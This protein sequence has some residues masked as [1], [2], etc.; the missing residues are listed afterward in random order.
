MV[1]FGVDGE[2]VYPPTASGRE[3]QRFEQSV[4]FILPAM[5]RASEMLDDPESMVTG[6]DE[7]RSEVTLSYDDWF[8][9]R[10]LLL[11]AR[12]G[13]CTERW[14]PWFNRVAKRHWLA[15]KSQGKLS[16]AE[17]RRRF[18]AKVSEMP[19]AADILRRGGS[20]DACWTLICPVPG[21]THLPCSGFS[22]AGLVA[23]RFV[24]PTRTP[25][26]E[27]AEA[28]RRKKLMTTPLSGH[29]K[30][31]TLEGFAGQ[32]RHV[33]TVNMEEYLQAF[34]VGIF[35]RKA[36]VAFTPE[37]YY[38]VVRNDRLCITM[39][40]PLGSRVEWL[41]PDGPP[42]RDRDPAGNN[43]TKTC[44]WEGEHLVSLFKSKEGLA[45][46]VTRRWVD[47]K[48]NGQQELIQVG[49]MR[50]HDLAPFPSSRGPRWSVSSHVSG[51]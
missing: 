6:F 29:G 37:P 2:L 42:E 14:P 34:G 35:G 38:H 1:D 39:T 9:L 7:K 27:E 25:T 12:F 51:H 26:L 36:A 47:E 46:I 13:A 19:G 4:T 15:W 17:A 30:A 40:T 41:I 22:L 20:F 23:I 18:V 5:E 28:S 33:E 31:G 11:C 3:H 44:M 43:F 48:P 21:G 10:G 8:L 49:S 32:W 45:D 50:P 24:Q 16:P